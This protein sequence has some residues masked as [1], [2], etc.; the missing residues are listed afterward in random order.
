MLTLLCIK[1]NTMY[2]EKEKL[3]A[4]I[5]KRIQEFFFLH[6]YSV[7]EV[8]SCLY[9]LMWQVLPPP[10][11]Y[12]ITIIQFMILMFQTLFPKF[13]SLLQRYVL[14]CFWC[15]P[16][17]CWSAWHSR[18]KGVNCI[19]RIVPSCSED[20]FTVISISDACC[21]EHTFFIACWSY[22]IIGMYYFSATIYFC[23]NSQSR[24]D[25]TVNYRGNL[26]HIFWLLFMC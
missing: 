6:C 8:K 9:H 12:L 17:Y 18:W 22:K 10:C 7:S 13:F 24:W 21:A 19:S 15:C 2:T 20:V 25:W 26:K 5:S 23:N 14:L 16:T 4:D 1:P 3:L 11:A